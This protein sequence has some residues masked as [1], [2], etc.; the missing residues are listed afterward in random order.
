MGGAGTGEI[1]SERCQI[2]SHMEVLKK[3]K[4]RKII[5]KEGTV[6]FCMK[7]HRFN[8]KVRQCQQMALA[9]SVFLVLGSVHELST[10]EDF[11]QG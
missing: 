6:W 10:R 4:S 2:L 3:S 9:G 7:L 5:K 11:L 1:I 8:T